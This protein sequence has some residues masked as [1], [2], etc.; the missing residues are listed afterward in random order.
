MTN[1]ATNVGIG[2]AL[3]AALVYVVLRFVVA[4]PRAGNIVESISQHAFWTALIAFFASGTSGLMNLW[5]NPDPQS[6][7]DSSIPT[8]V[9]HAAAPG[10]WLGIVYIL[11]QFTWPRHLQPVRSASLEVR[12]VKA[13]IPRALASVL[14]ACAAISTVLVIIAWNDPGAADRTATDAPDVYGYTQPWDGSRDEYGNPLDEWGYVMS[15]EEYEAAQNWVDPDQTD[16]PQ[17]TPISGTRPGAEVGPYLAGGLALV[18]IGCLTAATVIVRRPP[19]QPLDTEDNNVLRSIW[20][21][22]LLRTGVFVVSGFGMAAL[23]YMA[24]GIR[25]RSEWATET[26]GNGYSIDRQAESLANLLTGGG[27]VWML[28]VVVAMLAWKPPRLTH[29]AGPYRVD[30]PP[31]SA[32]YA[33]A[34]ARDFLVLAQGVGLLLVIVVSGLFGLLRSGNESHAGPAM[35][36]SPEGSQLPYDESPWMAGYDSAALQDELF[37]STVVLALAAGTYLLVQ[38]LAAYIVKRRL[39]TKNTP[40]EPKTTLLPAWFI[41]AICIATATGL[42]SGANLVFNAAPGVKGAAG[43]MLGVIAFTAVLAVLLYRTAASGPA[44]EGASEREDFEIRVLIAHRGARVLGG[45]SMIAACVMAN[46]DFWPPN[47]SEGG[48]VA[49]QI[50]CLGLGVFLCFLPA[51]TAYGQRTATPLPDV[52]TRA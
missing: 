31:V 29:I 51:F 6:P 7:S 21:N 27:T 2:L 23:A 12:S 11:G 17:V 25:A 36:V 35:M 18:L 49:F 13:V 34:R 5:A 52:P 30:V 46:E 41:V 8:M 32:G 15:P 48:R 42:G 47:A 26:A 50:I 4:T 39:G 10:L 40:A 28:A 44:L 38:L 22:R 43:W 16:S 3:S 20:I 24:E 19:L 33:R 1:A 14:L 9:M 45:V 37:V